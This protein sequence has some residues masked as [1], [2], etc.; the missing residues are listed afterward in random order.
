MILVVARGNFHWSGSIAMGGKE[1]LAIGPHLN[2]RTG[3][4]VWPL[5]DR[6]LNCHCCTERCQ[7]KH[8]KTAPELLC[9]MRCVRCACMCTCVCVCVCVCVHVNVASAYKGAP[10]S[11]V[12][13]RWISRQM[14]GRESACPYNDPFP[15]R[16]FI[17]AYNRTYT[18]T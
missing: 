7:C 1:R 17:Q 10:R 2:T 5:D 12:L 6:R 18:S 15:V 9:C 4:A 11:C 8:L 13:W 3:R 14:V 16:H